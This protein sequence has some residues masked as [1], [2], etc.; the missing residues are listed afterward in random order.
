MDCR[1][2][3][4]LALVGLFVR[5]RSFGMKHMFF[6]GAFNNESYLDLFSIM[7]FLA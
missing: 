1:L 6:V 3:I 5:I 4:G 2:G 7:F